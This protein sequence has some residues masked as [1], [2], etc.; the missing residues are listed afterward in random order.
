LELGDAGQGS[1]CGLTI[2]VKLPLRPSPDAY[3]FAVVTAED[4]QIRFP[5][6]KSL[7][8]FDLGR[9]LRDG[10]GNRDERGRVAGLVGIG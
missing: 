6:A 2:R 7:A 10:A 4:Q 3:G 1:S 5:M 9:P 8:I